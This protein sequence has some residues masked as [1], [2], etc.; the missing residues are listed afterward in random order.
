MR[1]ALQ[2]PIACQSSELVRLSAAYLHG[3]RVCQHSRL[4]PATQGWPRKGSSGIQRLQRPRTRPFR[5]TKF[6]SASHEPRVCQHDCSSP[7]IREQPTKYTTEESG[8]WRLKEVET[9]GFRIRKFESA[10]DDD[11]NGNRKTERSGA[12]ASSADARLPAAQETEG[13]TRSGLSQTRF[14]SDHEMVPM[15]QREILH[16]APDSRTHLRL[17]LRARGNSKG[18]TSH[19]MTFEQYQR[20]SNLKHFR[21][22]RLVDDPI[23]AQD[24]ELWLE[25]IVFRRRH[26]GAKGPIPIFKDIFRRGLWIPTQGDVAYQLWDLLIRASFHEPRLLEET[27]IYALLLKSSTE[28]SWPN[29]YYGVMSIALQKDPK[30]VYSWHVKLRDDFSPSLEGYQK[31]FEYFFDKYRFEQFEDIYK[32]Y[33]I[34]GMYKTVIWHLC[35]IRM[36]TEALR[37]H[38]ILYKAKDFPTEINDVQPLLT[39]LIYVGDRLRFENIVKQLAEIDVE[40][41]KKAEGLDQGNNIISREIVSRQLGQVHGVFPK[42][43]RDSFCARLFATRFFSVKTVISGLHMMAA[44]TIGPLSLREIA[45]RDN[46]EPSAICDHIDLLRDSGIHIDDSFF[47]K[48]V[49]S[50]ALEGKRAILNSVVNCDLHP[51]TFAD[52]KLQ[53]RLLAQYYWEDDRVQIERTLAVLTTGCSMKNLG[54]RRMNLVLRSQVTLGRYAKARAILEEMNVMNIPVSANSSRH[55]RVCWLSKRKNGRGMRNTHELNI[56]IKASQMSMQAGNYVP[57]KAWREILRRLGMSARLR[58]FE[59]LA[60]WLV[61]WYASPAAEAALAQMKVLRMNDQE[62]NERM[63]QPDPKNRDPQHVLNHLF[64][65]SA[66]QAI[67]T[68]GFQHKVK[69][70]RRVGNSAKTSNV[71]D[72]PQPRGTPRY[73]WTWGLHLLRK[74]QQ[75]GLPVRKSLVERSFRLRLDTLF[76]RGFSNRKINRRARADFQALGYYNKGQFIR[77]MEAIWGSSLML[78]SWRSVGKYMKK[79]RR[80]RTVW[81][82]KSSMASEE[83]EVKD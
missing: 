69:T 82:L 20:E 1:L 32:D 76:G 21:G 25:L 68:W 45:V 61:D 59:G 28:R 57:I 9:K 5:I 43:L 72:S 23:Y 16:R 81:R 30:S 41:S 22:P 37:W 13:V 15:I 70:R 38:D 34:I 50:L 46:C 10:T 48:L 24:W 14:R 75:R 19:L 17:P 2:S 79:R 54:L 58:E 6:E 63:W 73:R 74:L 52:Y 53:E 78:R 26:G 42:H 64:T 29:I 47:C 71:S 77:K 36:Y 31:L 7:A 40:I 12:D 83:K 66:M 3:P 8:T 55:M 56:L 18:W 60:L 33:P 44:N 49:R 4:S 39:H 27:L 80:P 51:D 35:E 11:K 62:Y 65:T 67:I